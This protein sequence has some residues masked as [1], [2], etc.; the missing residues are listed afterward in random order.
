MPPQFDFIS[1]DNIDPLVMYIFEFEYSFDKDDLSYMWQNIAPRDYRKVDMQFQSVAHEL[2]DTELL[3][4]RNLTESE[5]LRWM[6]FKVKQKAQTG[7]YDQVV[8]QAGQASDQFENKKLTDKDDVG[9][10]L[11]YNW[12]YDYLSFVELVKIDAEVLY[13]KPDKKD[14]S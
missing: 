13:K 3:S 12:P 14:E 9:Y 1:N 8:R 2:M 7:Y 11:N 10:Q 4:E 5:N 6:V